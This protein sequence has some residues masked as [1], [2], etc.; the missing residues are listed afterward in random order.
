M[1]RF[2][3]FWS[4]PSLCQGGWALGQDPAKLGLDLSHLYFPEA[5][6]WRWKIW[7]RN[8]KFISGVG[9]W[10]GA[11]RPPNPGFRLPPLA[12]RQTLSFLKGWV[13]A[14]VHPWSH[15]SLQG[16][17]FCFFLGLWD[18]LSVY[19]QQSFAWVCQYP[20]IHSVGT[21]WASCSVSLKHWLRMSAIDDAIPSLLGMPRILKNYVT[22]A[23]T[24][25]Q[26]DLEGRIILEII[27]SNPLPFCRWKGKGLERR[28]G[29]VQGHIV[30]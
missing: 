25:C 20:F 19:C 22:S 10:G 27:S 15:R 6:C 8:V 12:G 26:L 1:S 11:G 4:L 16:N 21:H 2:L 29:L 17:G 28:N 3:A 30:D 23:P 24:V 13:S 18:V 5:T 9:C 7:P 14:A